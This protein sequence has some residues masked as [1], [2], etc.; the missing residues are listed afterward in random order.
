MA[1]TNCHPLL[2]VELARSEAEVEVRLAGELDMSS[3]DAAAQEILRRC[4]PGVDLRLDLSG[5]TFLDVT[6]LH[7][8]RDAR[9]EAERRG[10][11]VALGRP[12]RVVRRLVELTESHADLGLG[13][14]AG[15]PAALALPDAALRSCDDAV[16]DALRGGADM[17]DVQL[18]DPT[19]ALRI[20]AQEGFGRA[21]LDFFEVV[22]DDES[23]CGVAL[24]SGRAV[25]VSD[26]T[27]SGIFAG[28]PSLD[29]MIDAGSRAVVS[30]PIALDGE[31]V[32]MLSA[33]YRQPTTAM[34]TPDLD[35]S[36]RALASVLTAVG[37][38]AA[39]D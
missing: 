22:H 39:G 4:E 24:R 17:A 9:R 35:R 18:R 30:V 16:S 13:P 28:R 20:V 38:P 36:A 6:G 2:R 14:D 25:W 37:P 31:C 29:A 11:H 1:W 15:A 10:V 3:A 27:R 5:V 33:H 26:V 8:V 12:H 19:G 23:A 7:A 34:E 32:G 21:F